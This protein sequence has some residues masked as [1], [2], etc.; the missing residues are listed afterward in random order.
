MGEIIEAVAWTA[1]DIWLG[2]L[3]M[4]AGCESSER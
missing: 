1:V 2:E 3:Q 4:L